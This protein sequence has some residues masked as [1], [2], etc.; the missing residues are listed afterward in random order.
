M[1]STPPRSHVIAA[2]ITL[3][4]LFYLPIVAFYRIIGS[5]WFHSIVFPIVY[6]TL[7]FVIGNVVAALIL[8]AASVPRHKN[9]AD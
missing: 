6:L 1:Q 9:D 8:T 7:G 2:R 3:A 5:G 4:L